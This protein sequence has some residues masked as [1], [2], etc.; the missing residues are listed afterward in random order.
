[1]KNRKKIAI[2]L[3]LFIIFTICLNN[4]YNYVSAAED[5]KVIYLTFDDGPGGQ[6]TEKVLDILKEEN[7]PATFFLIGDQFEGQEEVLKRIAEEGHSL[8]LH[9]MSHD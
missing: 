1:M 7:V 6:T 4:S 9:S 3:L 2:G 8:G 5:D